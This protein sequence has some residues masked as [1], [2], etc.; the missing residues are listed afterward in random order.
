[1]VDCKRM[2]GSLTCKCGASDW[3]NVEEKDYKNKTRYV[4]TCKNCGHIYDI[5]P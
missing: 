2:N 5:I 4:I 1:M 3:S